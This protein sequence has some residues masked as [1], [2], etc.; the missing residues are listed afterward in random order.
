MHPLSTSRFA[1]VAAIIAIIQMLVMM[2]CAWAFVPCAYAGC[3]AAALTVLYPPLF[4]VF[5]AF[6][7]LSLGRFCDLAKQIEVGWMDS[8][9]LWVSQ[10]LFSLFTSVDVGAVNM[11]VGG[12]TLAGILRP[13]ALVMFRVR[14]S[15]LWA[16]MMHWLLTRAEAYA[17]FVCKGT[18]EQ[19]ENLERL[20]ES[21]KKQLCEQRAKIG[22]LNDH[23]QEISRKARGCRGACRHDL[24]KLYEFF[25]GLLSFQ[26]TSP[27]KP[28]E[29]PIARS[30]TTVVERCASGS[31]M[32]KW[33]T[34]T[35]LSRLQAA[36]S[37]NQSLIDN[38]SQVLGQKENH[39]RIIAEHIETCNPAQDTRI[40]VLS[41]APSV[42]P[43]APVVSLVKRSEL[44]EDASIA[45]RILFKKT[46]RRKVWSQAVL[47]VTETASLTPLTPVL[48]EATAMAGPEPPVPEA[49]ESP[50]QDTD[51]APTPHAL[52]S[53]T[54]ASSE[55]P[56]PEGFD[57]K[58]YLAAL[59]AK[60]NKQT[61]AQEAATQAALQAAR[62]RLH[63]S[64][65]VLRPQQRELRR[66]RK[67]LRKRLDETNRR[68]KERTQE[69]EKKQLLLEDAPR[70]EEDRRRLD[71]QEQLQRAEERTA[72]FNQE[73]DA[74]Q[75]R[76]T[77]LREA[78]RAAEAE[79]NVAK[80]KAESA[81]VKEANLRRQLSQPASDNEVKS[82]DSLESEVDLPVTEAEQRISE[83]PLSQSLDA[84]SEDKESSLSEEESSEGADLGSSR[85]P[86]TEGTLGLA[87]DNHDVDLDCQPV[88][89]F[90][91]PIS[92]S[93]AAT[94]E[95]ADEAITIEVVSADIDVEAIA[96]TSMVSTP[97]IEAAISNQFPFLDGPTPIEVWDAYWTDR[98]SDAEFHSE[99]PKAEKRQHLHH[100]IH[101][102]DRDIARMTEAG[103]DELLAEIQ[104]HSQGADVEVAESTAVDEPMLD[105]PELE[106]QDEDVADG[107]D[108]SEL[109][110]APA[111]HQVAWPSQ[112]RRVDEDEE[113]VRGA[114]EELFPG[115]ELDMRSEYQPETISQP[116]L[117][118]AVVP[119]VE[120]T[121]MEESI[122]IN[123]SNSE[124]VTGATA[125][126]TMLC[127]CTQGD[128]PNVTEGE[129][130]ED[131]EHVSTREVIQEVYQVAEGA[132]CP[133]APEQPSAV[134][135]TSTTIE[136]PD[137][138]AEGEEE[139][140]YSSIIEEPE[141][142]AEGEEDV[143]P[144][145]TTNEPEAD[146][147][148]EEDVTHSNP[149]EEP[150]ARAN[151]GE[152]GELAQE[153]AHRARPP[154]PVQQA[155]SAIPSAPALRRVFLRPRLGAAGSA[156]ARAEAEL[157]EI[158]ERQ[159]LAAGGHQPS[160]MAS[161][162]AEGSS[163]L[164]KHNAG[165][166]VGE[167]GMEVG[168]GEGNK[169]QQPEANV[170][171]ESEEESEEESEDYENMPDDHSS[172]GDDD[173]DD[174]P[175]P[176]GNTEGDDPEPY[177]ANNDY[178]H[179]SDDEP[180]Q[181]DLED[182]YGAH[183]DAR[184]ANTA[185]RVQALERQ[186]EA[187]ARRRHEAVEES[188]RLDGP[189]R[190]EAA[191]EAE[192]LRKEEGKSRRQRA[193]E[194]SARRIAT[195]TSTTQQP[196]KRGHDDDSDID[197]QAAMAT[198]DQDVPAVRHIRVPDKRATTEQ[199]TKEE[200]KAV[201]LF[202]D[203]IPLMII[204]GAMPPKGTI[205][206]KYNFKPLYGPE[207][208]STH[209]GAGNSFGTFGQRQETLD[210]PA[211]YL[212]IP[213]ELHRTPQP[214]P[215]EKVKPDHLPPA[216]S[217]HRWVQF[218]SPNQQNKLL[219][220][221]EHLKQRDAEIKAENERRA[222]RQQASLSVSPAHSPRQPQQQQPGGAPQRPRVIVRRPNPQSALRQPPRPRKPVP[223]L[224]PTQP[225]KPP[226]DDKDKDEKMSEDKGND[227]DKDKGKQI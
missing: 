21:A 216:P 172:D 121:V 16:A 73:V 163:S 44:R 215:T 129:S 221:Q 77:D 173:S 182:D 214:P 209:T 50:V 207:T 35:G 68:V 193:Q 170:G 202:E 65:T 141:A 74:H 64:E 226:D 151:G 82:A 198:E 3:F 147:D 145:T 187:N 98:I 71:I 75:S 159:L 17:D 148:G 195:T 23:C 43:K 85:E 118:T 96:D 111:P 4:L 213:S 38:L 6:A 60:R 9:L 13:L 37:V 105:A 36:I 144:S 135:A 183:C 90:I 49:I 185:A 27:I 203:D 149:I 5:L 176:T 220:L 161:E 126:V 59:E 67:Q 79:L 81:K 164:I 47:P 130:N 22:D 76:V 84:D 175:H 138:D 1:A 155:T 7:L 12:S 212:S 112:Q 137:A 80:E 106:T 186:S 158:K 189:R 19:R 127:A 11:V 10:M 210:R 174:A 131:T 70:T 34:M 139:V 219:S 103:K 206:P 180:E 227:E 117:E 100:I 160:S 169:G 191:L 28:E 168:D 95:A 56:L 225:D 165:G 102:V 86:E 162:S 177:D 97:E 222:S 29:G 218:K 42:E 31:D 201:H 211:R 178:V 8:I 134:S 113:Q 142:N 89:Q 200:R 24:N 199:K 140:I 15:S 104:S 205:F 92:E 88:Q 94:T 91:Q 55:G 25:E 33:W 196:K 107:A 72:N 154:A 120:D 197:G 18:P 83:R 57:H 125:E 20:F 133:E 136:E 99:Y 119:I 48:D 217:G 156:R 53:P 54:P 115:S 93:S 51:H 167:S 78:L 46:N 62:E 188:R 108:L 101:E 152:D 157:R 150:E 190:A 143:A 184:R 116:A 26:V 40:I 123:D 63:W 122:L 223:R 171:G 208:F 192:R 204:H 114:N 30:F 132:C 224:P 181:P 87:A 109:P 128:E 179:P 39:Y 66:S 2:T 61:A 110:D 41:R 124:A 32:S 153:V 14:S 194:Y 166:D 45:E 52:P 58:A 146:A 69:E